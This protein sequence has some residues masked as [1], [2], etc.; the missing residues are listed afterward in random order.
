MYMPWKNILPSAVQRYLQRSY[1]RR[2]RGR[3]G[4]AGRLSN[5]QENQLVWDDYAKHWDADVAVDDATLDSGGLGYLGDEWGRK[6]DVL[7]IVDEYIRPYVAT[8]SVVGE[9][10]SGG[11]RVSALVAGQVGELHCFDISSEMLKRAQAALAGF[12]NVHFRHLREP[13]LGAAAR[14]KFDFI[15]SFDVFVH[16]DL[17]VTWQYFREIAACLKPGGRAFLHTANLGA[18]GGWE[19]FLSQRGD[20]PTDHH[21]VSPEII[22][23]FAAHSNV[24]IIKRSEIDPANFYLNRDYLFVLEKRS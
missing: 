16:L 20:D 13:R 10:G 5:W 14:E 2:L 24:G 12:S 17:V 19:N 21:F 11:G 9:I 6:Q 1:Y 23:I 18:P 7:R 8:S 3:D 15:Y 4:A 22:D